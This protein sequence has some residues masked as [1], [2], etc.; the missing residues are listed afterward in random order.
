MKGFSW[1][2]SSRPAVASVG[3]GKPRTASLFPQGERQNDIALA[4][5]FLAVALSQ[6]NREI[7][8]DHLLGRH[9]DLSI[10]KPTTPLRGRRVVGT[11][12]ITHGDI[13]VA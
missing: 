11:F 7:G 6:R 2:A 4:S 3:S 8:L 10:E 12:A 13:A 5:G 1:Q 9:A